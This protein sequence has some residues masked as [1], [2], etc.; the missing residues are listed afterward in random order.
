MAINNSV[1]LAWGNFTN[2]SNNTTITYPCTFNTIPTTIVQKSGDGYI[3]TSNG[4]SPHLL[5][6]IQMDSISTFKIYCVWS[7][8]NG[9]YSFSGKYI[10]CGY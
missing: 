10:V 2:I 5:I 7:T 4:N 3:S 9:T 6:D 8:T 1:K